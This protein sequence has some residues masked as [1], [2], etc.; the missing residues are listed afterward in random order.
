MESKHL[1]RLSANIRLG[2]YLH[3]ILVNV[4]FVEYTMV[5]VKNTPPKL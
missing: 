1:R 4:L 3:Y 2:C 5:E